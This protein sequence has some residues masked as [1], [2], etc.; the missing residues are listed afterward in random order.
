MHQ[1]EHLEAFAPLERRFRSEEEE[2]QE[3]HTPTN[4][5]ESHRAVTEEAV[6]IGDVRSYSWRLTARV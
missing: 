6:Q 5:R 1:I 2:G 3:T 4:S